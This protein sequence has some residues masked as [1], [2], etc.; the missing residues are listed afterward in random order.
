MNRFHLATACCTAV[1]FS[2]ALQAQDSEEA[3]KSVIA[4]QQQQLPI[5]LDPATRVDAITYAN[6]T[7]RY[8][9]TLSG[10]QGQPGEQAY[11]HSFLT[12]QIDKSLCGQTAYLLM[13]A[14][15][16]HITYQYVSSTAAPIT[17]ITLAPDHCS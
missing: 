3:L 4:K 17:E 10:Y 12:Q 13:L 8:T 14:L 2:G 11:Y 1:L 5:M 6:H 9:I 7:V 16:N 15:G